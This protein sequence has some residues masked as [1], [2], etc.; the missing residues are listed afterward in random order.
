[1]EE[2]WKVI[3]GYE[4]YQVSNMGRV[5]NITTGRILKNQN[6]GN[7]YLHVG[8]YNNDHK[9]K[10]IMVH[11][12]VAKAFILNPNN[13]PQVNHIDECK[14]NNRADNLEWITSEDNINHGTHNI[15]VGVNNPNRK[16]IY[17]VDE[18]GN[19]IYYDSARA[20]SRY[21]EERGIKVLPGGIVKALK[22]EIFTYKNLAWFYQTDLSGITEY[23]KKFDIEHGIR[24]KVYCVSDCGEVKHF[25]SM[26]SA[27]Q[28]F[29]LP[30]YQRCNLRESINTQT[31]FNGLMWFY[32]T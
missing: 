21:W 3:D 29:N 12:L 31:K 26:L 10:I 16:P 27:L 8:L 5:I 28:F 4:N 13:L 6:N 24:K 18:F 7:G 22:C 9:C 30:E 25:T 15:R 2:I 1:M 32:G 17:S 23:V 19:V 14:T 20:A 11:R